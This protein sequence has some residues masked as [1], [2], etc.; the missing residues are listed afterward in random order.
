MYYYKE[1]ENEQIKSFVS[2]NVIP[3]FQPKERERFFE[4]GEEE[5]QEG[6]AGMSRKREEEEAGEDITEEFDQ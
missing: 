4:I 2:Y 5:F 1:M 3:T 6:I